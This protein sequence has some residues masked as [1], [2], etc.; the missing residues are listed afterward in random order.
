MES[1]KALN[2][3]MIT[4]VVPTSCE[5]KDYEYSKNISIAKAFPRLSTLGEDMVLYKNYLV[6]VKFHESLTEGEIERIC[7][8]LSEKSLMD[9]IE[10]KLKQHEEE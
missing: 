6:N 7:E 1:N 4:S 9:L 3:L 10:E 5:R 8:A 2:L